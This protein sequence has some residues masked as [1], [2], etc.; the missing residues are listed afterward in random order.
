MS[1]TLSILYVLRR[2]KSELENMSPQR[3]F[4]SKGINAF[5]SFKKSYRSGKRYLK[6]LPEFVD[7]VM[8]KLAYKLPAKTLKQTFSRSKLPSQTMLTEETPGS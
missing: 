1:P 2:I 8:K 5:P 6:K 7:A 4:H 3:S